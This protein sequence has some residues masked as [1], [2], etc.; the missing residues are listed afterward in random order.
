MILSNKRT[1]YS[2]TNE[3][4]TLKLNGE[5][6]ISENN[7]ITGFHGSFISLDNLSHQGGFNYSEYEETCNKNYHSLPISLGDIPKI[8]LDDTISQIKSQLTE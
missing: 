8:L 7:T 5:L 2:V 1:M 6:T 4:S 3:N